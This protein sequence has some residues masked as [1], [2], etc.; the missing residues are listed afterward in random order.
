VYDLSIVTDALRDILT[1]ALATSPL[2]GGVPAPFSVAISSQHPDSEVSGADVDLNLFLFHVA[3]NK[4]VRNQFWTHN[5]ISGQPAGT[6]RQPVAFEPLCL[7]LW[8]VLSALAE[9]SYQQEQQV[10]SIALRAFHQQPTVRLATPTPTGVPESQVSLTMDTPTPDELSR[11][12]QALGV[13]LRMTAHYRAS[14]ALLM[15]ETG[16]TEHPHPTTWT[17]LAAPEDDLSERPL[18]YGTQRRVVFAGPSGPSQYDQ[19]PATTTAAPGGVDS[20]RFVLRG[21]GVLATDDILLVDAAGTET[22]VSSWRDGELLRP[23]GTCP[24]PGRFR[25]RIGRG[26]LRS[27]D[28]PLNIGAYVDPTGGPLIT[29]D[30]SGIFSFDA[31]NV[32]AARAELRLGSILLARRTTGVPGAGQWRFSSGT[33]RFRPPTG[34]PPGRYAVRLRCADVESDPALWAVVA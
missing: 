21:T 8:Y 34:T 20:Q 23:D 33:I 26:S 32:P 31:L 2:F 30:G 27:N 15:P 4:H 10:M 14:V 13:P 1:D 25:L 6:P 22:D 24:E 19:T 7:D 3:E 29:P 5:A 9:G 16:L 28:V 17:L 18:L 12:W 11:F